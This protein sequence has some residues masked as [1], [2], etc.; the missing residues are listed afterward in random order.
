MKK[1]LQPFQE[2]RDDLLHPDLKQLRD[3]VEDIESDGWGQL[4]MS[5]DPGFRYTGVV[6][7]CTDGE[8]MELVWGRVVDSRGADNSKLRTKAG[9]SPTKIFADT[10]ACAY[11]YKTLIKYVEIVSPKIVFF[12]QPTGCARSAAAL[13]A[14]WISYLT[15]LFALEASGVCHDAVPAHLLIERGAVDTQRFGSDFSAAGTC[16][17]GIENY[18]FL[19]FRYGSLE[20]YDLFLLDFLGLAGL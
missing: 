9:A 15:V 2:F 5:I 10:Q 20:R 7:F 1:N 4:V 14:I 13:K 19:P 12:E 6:L 8:Y 11:L 16:L 17:Q 3:K 18:S